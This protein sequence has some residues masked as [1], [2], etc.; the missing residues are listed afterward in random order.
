MGDAW[1]ERDQGA[2]E[3]AGRERAYGESWEGREE[4]REALAVRYRGGTEGA[5]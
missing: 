4:A 1:Q 2:R 3:A 5:R